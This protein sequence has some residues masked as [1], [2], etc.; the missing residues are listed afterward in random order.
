MGARGTLRR[1]AGVAI[2][3]LVLWALVA[4][5]FWVAVGLIPGIDLPSFRA[6][7]LT[8][9]LIVLINALLWPLVIRVVLPLTVSTFG[10]ASLALNAG[11]VAVAIDA[12]DGESPPFLAALAAAFALSVAMMLLTPALSFDD[13]AR[14]L[15]IVR[16]RARG[17]RDANR[18][19]IPGVILFE[20]DGLAEPVL[21]HALREGHVPIMARWLEQGTHRIVPWECDLSSQTGAS[22]AGLL[23]GDN[24]DM[25]AF[26][27]YEKESGRTMVS[28][29]GKDAAELE[30][31]HSD[32]GG[33]LAMDGTSR[34]NM[35]S[36]DAQRCSAT[37]SVIRDRRRSSAKEY[38][39]YFADPY[40]FTRTIALYLWD[41]ILELRSARRQRRQ[42]EEHIHRGGLYPLMRGAIT[43]IMRDLNVATLMGDIV[44]GVP[45]AYSTF[46]GYDEVAH[47]SGIEQPDAL[48]VLK[49]HDAQLA[50]LERAVE[51]APRPYHMVVLSDHGQSQ[52]RP[53]RQRYQVELGDLVQDALRGG[54][55]FA[56]AASDEGL[57][58]V[59]GA[60]TDARDEDNAGARMLAR[61]TRNNL[62]D[63]EVVL[64]PNRDAVEE[65]RGDASE[66]EAV[67][68][69]SGGLG[70][71]Y[72][73]ERPH[74]M[75][76]G[77][78]D[79]LHPRL[80]SALTSHPGI[81]FVMVRADDDGATVL[82]ARGSRRLRDNAV[83]GEDPLRPFG[84][85]A[86]DHLRRTDGFPHCP[87][88]LVNCIYDPEANEVAPFEE[89]MGSHGG[90]GGWQSHP[91]ALVPAA[92]SE[93][94]GPVVGAGAM[95]EALRTWLAE[96]GLEL[97]PHEPQ[98]HDR[99][100][101]ERVRIEGR[102]AER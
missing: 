62:V 8:T 98:G 23:L 57:S 71:I 84:K 46:V 55:V 73:T 56:P 89:F 33:L 97:K 9:A 17:M 11:V 74:R 87:D 44:E 85:N 5:A 92:W 82:G 79:R 95:H 34:G 4:L 27:W 91:F 75:T 54:D 47:H 19:E 37:M 80:L 90:I 39:A 6:A 101:A 83:S 24:H 67:V 50:R 28:N 64:G 60:L 58:T 22:Q 12:V 13:D 52:G 99:D 102:T 100:G 41:V 76:I 25:P 10:L 93:L 48:A 69:A 53:F 38:F 61:A 40:G 70:L 1:V 3:G 86:A 35:F 42:G 51:Q 32:G 21:R 7:L 78:I 49:Q 26:R 88:L 43:V 14:Q 45:V 2:R 16:R 94:K 36:G 72:L 77:E 68:L 15:R 31:R 65:E 63:G 59:G 20:I 81:A 29:H 66:H 96:T 30:R 18:T